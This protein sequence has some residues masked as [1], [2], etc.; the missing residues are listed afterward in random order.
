VIKDGKPER[1]GPKQ[2]AKFIRKNFV[3]LF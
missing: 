1:L 2:Q 3:Q